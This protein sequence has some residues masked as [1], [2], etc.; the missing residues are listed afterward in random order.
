MSVRTISLD[1]WIED[2]RREVGALKIHPCRAEGY[3]WLSSA[4]I[5]NN[6]SAR[7]R[8]RSPATQPQPASYYQPTYFCEVKS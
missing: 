6:S 8:T 7:S 2:A 1:Q 5:L 4:E 3:S